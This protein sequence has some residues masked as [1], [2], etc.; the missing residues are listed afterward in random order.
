MRY[1]PPIDFKQEDPRWARNMFSNHGDKKQ[2]MMTSGMGP[3]LAADVVYELS[4][5]RADPWI[6]AQQCM[7]WDCRSRNSGCRWNF[8]SEVA[9][10]YGIERYEETESWEKV[11]E[12]LDAGGLVICS[13]KPRFYRSWPI[14]VLAWDYDI[15]DVWCNVSFGRV[16]K[17]RV[18]H[19][20]F[21]KFFRMGFCYY[22]NETKKKEKA[23]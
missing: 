23:I 2:T 10:Q 17:W 3:T 22:P 1:E 8:F 12:C 21:M 15:N 20:K 19:G 18:S 6:L 13:M 7:N 16:K 11:K 5:K 14:L 9:K 4:D